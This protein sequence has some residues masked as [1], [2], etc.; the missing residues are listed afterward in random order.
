MLLGSPVILTS[1][2]ASRNRRISVFLRSRNLQGWTL[3]T[4]RSKH[5]WIFS[6][7]ALKG[8]RVRDFACCWFPAVATF[9][10]VKNVH[11]SPFLSQRFCSFFW[12]RGLSA[13]ILVQSQSQSHITTDSQSASPSW[14]QAPIWDPRPICLSPSDFLLDSCGLLLC[15]ALSD[16]RTGL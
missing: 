12:G 6:Q 2:L 10:Q 15:S 14:C 7:A 1:G 8:K 3:V 5:T 13:I 16:E 11:V 4:P 9:L